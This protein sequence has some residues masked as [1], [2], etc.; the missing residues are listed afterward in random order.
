LDIEDKNKPAVAKLL[1]YL[2]VV[3]VV[4]AGIG[5][6]GNDLFLA[7][8]QWLLIAIILSVWGIYILVEAFLSKN[9]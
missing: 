4:L 5:A 8:T 3:G 9:R 6:T 2:S 7:S 1:I